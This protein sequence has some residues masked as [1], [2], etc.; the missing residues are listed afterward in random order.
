MMGTRWARFARGWAVAGFSM[1]VAALSHTLGGGAAPGTM[2][3]VFSLAFAGIICIG[4]TG[5]TL[6]VWRVGA[7]V[8]ISQL[9]FHGLFSLG[10][11]AGALA[12]ATDASGGVALAAHQHTAIEIVHSAAGSAVAHGPQHTGV[13]MWMAHGVAALVTIA[14]LRH[15][16]AALWGLLANARLVSRRV[17]TLAAAITPAAPTRQAPTSGLV[18][19]ARELALVLSVMRHRGP[20]AGVVSA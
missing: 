12:V 19:V 20:P 16:E 17:V 7:S 18:F 6:S 2:G 14:A 15:G 10:A 5:R 3:V 8:I 9:I 4:L 11:T 13:G 1:F